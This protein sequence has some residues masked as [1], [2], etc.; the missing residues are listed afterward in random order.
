MKREQDEVIEQAMARL[1]EDY[2]Q[3]I[4]LWHHRLGPAAFADHDSIGP[5]PQG[6]A[7]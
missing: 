6:V 1:P 5:H 4:R 2:R 3:V 7:H